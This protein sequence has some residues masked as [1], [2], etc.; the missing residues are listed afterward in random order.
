MSAIAMILAKSG[1]S[2]SGS[3]LKKS[4]ILTELKAN[5]INI[6]ERQ[7]A[8]NIDK[9]IEINNKNKNILVVISS[10]IQESNEELNEAK[11]S[12]LTIK[13]RSEILALLIDKQKSIVVSGSHGKTTTSTYISTILTIA[14]KNPTAVIGGIVPLYK[15]NYNFGNGKLLVAEADESDGSLIKF[16]PH[17]GIIT[18]LELE[19]VDHYKNLEDL[20]QTMKEFGRNCKYLIGNADCHNIK[21]NIQ[22][23]TWFSTKNIYNIDFALIPKETNGFEIVAEYY[24]KE[25]FIDLIKIPIPGIHNLGNT[26]AAIAATRK[27]GL[28]FNDIK[29]GIEKLQ[30]PERRFDYKGLWKNRLIVDDYA[31][32]PSEID[33]AISMAALMIKTKNNFFPIPPNRLVTV[34]QPHRFSR[35]KKFE[36]QFAKSLIKSD[37][38]F[39]TPIYSAGEDAIDG[40]NNKILSQQI[41]RFKP[42]LEVYAPNNNQELIK[43]LINK[44]KPQDLILMMGAGDIN[45]VLKNLF[46]GTTQNKPTIYDLAA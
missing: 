8:V 3:D 35:T 10:A 17:I 43:L 5:G 41:K 6:F 15:K 9:I 24:E 40:I 33:A 32:H 26:I 19:H 20:I 29:K 27:I 21:N 13:H 14:N 28:D 37:L 45:L 7:E 23:S 22:S 16:N 46:F 25:K 44:T 18:N 34:F 12:N 4:S 39:V 1:Y 38:V 30:L 2:I 36:E 31:H 11:K 42:S